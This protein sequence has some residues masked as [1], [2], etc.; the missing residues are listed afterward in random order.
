MLK[1]IAGESAKNLQRYLQLI[2]KEAEIL[3]F[4]SLN[5]LFIVMSAAK[6]L[7]S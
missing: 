2:A 6:Y 4:I 3:T 5:I 1:E 7:I